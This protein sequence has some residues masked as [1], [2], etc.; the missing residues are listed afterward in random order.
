MNKNLFSDRNR[1]ADFLAA[2]IE[3]RGLGEVDYFESFEEVLAERQ[4]GDK[5]SFFLIKEDERQNLKDAV[6]LL[7]YCKNIEDA[8]IRMYVF[9]SSDVAR[10]VLDSMET[11][12]AEINLL[13]PE[14]DAG[15][16]AL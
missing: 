5:L 1:Q 13:N 15:S 8:D 14:T 6:I 12:W 7:K 3:A 9:S 10:T 16:S 4:K 11:Q 2:D